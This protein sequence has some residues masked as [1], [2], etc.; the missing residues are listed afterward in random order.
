[1]YVRLQRHRGHAKGP[2]LGTMAYQRPTDLGETEP[3]RQ[4]DDAGLSDSPTGDEATPAAGPDSRPGML[5]AVA[6][7]VLFVAVLVLAIV[8]GVAG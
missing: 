4:T 3:A 5:I 6:F 2:T 1:M 7:L 8:T